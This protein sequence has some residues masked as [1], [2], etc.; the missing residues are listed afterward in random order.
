MPSTA[1][2][3]LYRRRTQ[4]VRTNLVPTRKRKTTPLV[5]FDPID[6][7]DFLLRWNPHALRLF[8]DQDAG[9][10]CYPPENALQAGKHRKL[11]V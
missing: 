11:R 9:E 2:R 6:P 8:G 7:V 3:G 10:A 4:L 1:R 5:E